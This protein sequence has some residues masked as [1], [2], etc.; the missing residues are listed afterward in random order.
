MSRAGLLILE[1]AFVVSLRDGRGRRL[2]KPDLRVE[3]V[4]GEFRGR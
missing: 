3:V 4:K 1:V 2:R